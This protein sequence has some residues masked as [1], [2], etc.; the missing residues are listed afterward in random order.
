MNYVYVDDLYDDI[1]RTPPPAGQV[2]QRGDIP[3]E[4]FEIREVLNCWYQA[5]FVPFIEDNLEQIN[6]W[7]RVEEFQRL[8]RTIALLIRCKAYQSAVKRIISLWQSESLECR[9]LHYLLSKVG[10]Q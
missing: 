8:T 7:E 10:R 6:F 1:Y 9:Y 2:L 4:E 3:E 5:G